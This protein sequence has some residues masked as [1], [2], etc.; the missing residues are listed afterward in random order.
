M[1]GKAELQPLMETRLSL[2]NRRSGKV[3]DIYDLQ[4]ESGPALL[5]V[6][7]DRVSS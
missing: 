2:P 4:L 6:A 3:R 1:T 7:T 5:L